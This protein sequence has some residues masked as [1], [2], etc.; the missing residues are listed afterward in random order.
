MHYKFWSDV[1]GYRMSIIQKEV[2]KQAVVDII[3]KEKLV[4][5]CALISSF[6]LYECSVKD[7]DFSSPF[8][9]IATMDA[10]VTTLVGYF[11]VFFNLEE[12]IFFSTGPL[13]QPTH[14]KQT[15]FH[16]SEPISMKK[17][18]L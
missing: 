3:P 6:N 14:W 12:K 2:V 1:Y 10:T 15:L 7:T 11:N 17:G 9:L 8:E 18:E 13:V 16:I 4:T 5:S